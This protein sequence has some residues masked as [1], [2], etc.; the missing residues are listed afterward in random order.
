[1]ERSKKICGVSLISLYKNCLPTLGRDKSGI[2]VRRDNG[3]LSMLSK[4]TILGKYLV[5][6]WPRIKCEIYS[7][8]Y[9]VATTHFY[10][11]IPYSSY[12][13]Y[14]IFI[15]II[16]CSEFKGGNSV[17]SLW[18]DSFVTKGQTYMVTQRRNKAANQK[19]LTNLM[20]YPQNGAVLIICNT[21]WI[22]DSFTC[23]V[24]IQY[25]AILGKDNS[26]RFRKQTYNIGGK[27]YLFFGNI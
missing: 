19:E 13:T 2:G 15:N 11:T 21:F 1:M 24:I 14:F 6:L 4:E 5:Y 10:F 9:T 20:C 18:S 16:L 3:I 22:A 27:L 17:T 25:F 7:L 12:T 8:T 23:P 26:L